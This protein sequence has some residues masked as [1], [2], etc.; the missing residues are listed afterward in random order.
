MRVRHSS[1][2]AG[3][4][5][6]AG[7]TAAPRALGLH[8][9]FGAFVAVGLATQ[10]FGQQAQN[11]QPT[12]AAP[13]N[14]QQNQNPP[15]FGQQTPAPVTPGT[16]TGSDQPPA[17]TS[18]PP[19]YVHPSV[20]LD[21]THSSNSTLT[22]DGRGDTIVDAIASLVVHYSGPSVIVDGNFS[23][24]EIDYLDHTQPSMLLPRGNLGL[25]ADLYA[26]ILFL[27][28]GISSFQSPANPFLGQTN[29]PS[30]YNMVSTTQYHIDP[31]LLKP[32]TPDIDLYIRSDNLFS[33]SSYADQNL[34]LNDGYGGTQTVRVTDRPQPLGWTAEVLDTE[35]RFNGEQ[36][37]AYKDAAARLTLNYAINPDLVT[38]IVG[39]YES[40]NLQNIHT[41]HAI[42]G[43]HAVWH[44]SERTDVEATVES[45]FFGTGWDLLATDHLDLASFNAR[46]LRTATTYLSTLAIA[47]GTTSMSG[48]LSGILSAQYPDPLDR[49][50]AV[51][52]EQDSRGL[53]QYLP[54]A[55]TVFTENPILIDYLSATGL[56]LGKLQSLSLTLYSSR[57]QDLYLP[58][59]TLVVVP[60]EF[61]V[62]NRQNGVVINYSRTLAATTTADV[63]L[64]IN[65]TQAI[66]QSI[67]PNTHQTAITAR[68]NQKFDPK[69]T[70]YVGLRY[71][72]LD[73]SGQA[74]VSETAEFVGM[75]LAF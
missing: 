45:R 14:S 71:Q 37:D 40:A 65:D 8:A 27:D 5:R 3:I 17:D 26:H 58:G 62:N 33:Q 34:A 64:Q 23:L 29:G 12:Q 10:A 46:W 44:P 31:Y 55:A 63:S 35:D 50:A 66:G 20:T 72:I 4:K 36:Y 68:L 28:T 75:T 22:P 11:Q 52:Q 67:E 16:S 59:E 56:L 69:L 15:V 39:G 25:A 48:L 38:G 24:Q 51:Q 6:R 60:G 53:T 73:V 42:Y 54:G 61:D 70:G 1:A 74:R 30:T 21:A 43:V 9:L 7:K 19:W 32:L 47:P 41:D 18:N 49:A 57:T 13:V 2:H